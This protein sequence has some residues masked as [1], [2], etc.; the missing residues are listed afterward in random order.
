MTT[1]RIALLLLLVLGLSCGCSC[2]KGK[3][4]EPAPEPGNAGIQASEPGDFAFQIYN[5]MDKPGKN[6]FYSPYSISSALA[7]VWGGAK[8]ATAEQ[9]AQ[10]LG[11]TLPPKEQHA[12]FRKLQLA[13]NEIG[14]RGKAELN[15]ANALFGA[16]KYK[17]LLLQDYLDLL[18]DMYASDLYSLNFG[19]PKGT[20]KFIND[21]VEKKTKER[22]KNLISADAIQ[23]SN[24]G[25]VLVNAIYF[26]GNWLKQFDPKATFRDTFYASSRKREAE[27]ARPVDMMYLEGDFAYAEVPGYQLLEM[28]YAEKDLAMLFVLPDEIDNQKKVLSQS[29]YSK[30]RDALQV[31]EVKAYIPK[32][33]VEHTL[34]GLAGTLSDLGIK[35]AFDAGLADF[36]GIREPGIADLYIMDV[37]H[38]AFVEV[39]EE[40][41]EAAAATGV[42]MA[43]K[44][45]PVKPIPVFR[46]DRPFL[47]L[48]VHRPSGTVLFLGKLQEP[49]KA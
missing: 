23:D 13:L 15:V 2:N 11:F 48:I 38:K 31:Q 40:G 17:E 29:V 7:M 9:M 14:D 5:Q 45:A 42:I 37:V 6:I 44:A 1:L 35:D 16:D 25:I 33:K 41:T 49:S 39:N 47:Y 20:A 36:T 22:I 12:A 4:Q 26:K 27:F 24:D 46:A 30:W 3:D 8:G 10:A 28:P 19:D 32:F 21:W 34:E 43:T 18:R